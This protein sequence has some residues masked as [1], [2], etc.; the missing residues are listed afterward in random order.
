MDQKRQLV[1]F[2]LG[3]L[4]AVAMLGAFANQ[5]NASVFDDLAE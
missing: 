1:L 5:A 4:K 3:Q 2:A